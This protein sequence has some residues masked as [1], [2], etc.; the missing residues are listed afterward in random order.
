VVPNKRLD[1]IETPALIRALLQEEA[2]EWATANKGRPVT[3]YFLRDNLR[4]LLDPRGSQEWR[5]ED[6]Q[7][8]RGYYRSQFEASWAAYLPATHAPPQPNVASGKS[9][10]SGSSGNGTDA[11]GKPTA[12]EDETDTPDA[13]D[14]SAVRAGSGQ[15]IDPGNRPAPLPDGP[16]DPHIPDAE[17]GNEGI[18]PNRAE[19]SPPDDCLT[20]AVRE[21]VAA[22]PDW[23][24]EAIAKHLGQLRA[25]A[26]IAAIMA[27]LPRP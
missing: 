26:T 8:H 18:S 17:A 20:A 2:E 22:H 9:G 23:S 7:H 14:N 13:A 15:E 21:L 10:R 12:C 11:P 19:E 16:D 5:T 3:E 27:S 6:G 4:G 24:A 1:R 25:K